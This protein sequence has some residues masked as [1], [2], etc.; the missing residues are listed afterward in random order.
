MVKSADEII[1]K[2]FHINSFSDISIFCNLFNFTFEM[3]NEEYTR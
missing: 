3:I 2:D 1:T